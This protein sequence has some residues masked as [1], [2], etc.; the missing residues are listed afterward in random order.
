MTFNVLLVEDNPG[1]ATLVRCA[2]EDAQLNCTLHV[3]QNKTEAIAFLMKDGPGKD[4]PDPAIILLDWNLPAGG[5]AVLNAIREIDGIPRVP[6]IIYSSS[7]SPEDIRTAYASGA[8]C[9]ISKGVLLDE[10]FETI[11]DTIRFW[12]RVA[13]VPNH[14]AETSVR[15]VSSAE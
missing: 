13:T 8:N 6:I 12:S 4:A 9:W 7:Q 11:A 10:C 2:I 14:D 15:G 1:D 5:E 3:A